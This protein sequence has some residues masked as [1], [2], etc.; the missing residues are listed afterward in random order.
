MK[1]EPL[2]DRVNRAKARWLKRVMYGSETT[3]AQRCLAYAIADYLNCVTLDCWP[4]HATLARLLGYKSARTVRRAAFGL[5]AAKQIT[6]KPVGKK[7]S[8]YRYAPVFRPG[9]LDK[10]VLGTGHPC[11]AGADTDVHQ[12]FLGILPRSSSTEEASEGSKEQARGA[13]SFKRAQ[14]GAIELKLAELLGADGFDVLSDLALIDDAVVDRL[15]RAFAAGQVGGRELA[16]ARLAAQ[17][18][19]VTREP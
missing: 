13:P 9:D 5:Q 15:C 1:A 11:P 16:V 7:N 2:S 8:G 10:V 3:P 6:I 18:A 17:Q 12:S 19:R 14:R 4:S